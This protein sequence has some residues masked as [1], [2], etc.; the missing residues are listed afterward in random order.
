MSIV[1]GLIASAEPSC[2]HALQERTDE[3]NNKIKS[4]TIKK[5]K[6][7]QLYFPNDIWTAK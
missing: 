3:I 2:H 7:D 6:V 4:S 5:R 1:L